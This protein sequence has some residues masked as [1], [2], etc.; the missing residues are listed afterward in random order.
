MVVDAT[1]NNDAATRRT[2]VLC[3]SNRSAGMGREIQGAD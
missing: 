1:R 3:E 2:P